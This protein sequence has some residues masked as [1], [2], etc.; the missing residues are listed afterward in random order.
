MTSP[1]FRAFSAHEAVW[2]LGA[3]TRGLALGKSVAITGVAT[4]TRALQP[5]DVFVAL[6]GKN[7]D[8]H[9]YL[10]QAAAAGASCAIVSN[11]NAPAM[12]EAPNLPLLLVNDTQVA[13]GEL[14]RW[15]RNR[16]D[17]LVIAITGTNGKTTVKEMLAHILAGAGPTLSTHKNENN[18]I[19][20]PKTLLRLRDDHAFA[21]IECGTSAPGEIARQAQ[22]AEPDFAILT[23]VGHGHLEGLGSFAGVVREKGA[24]L[25]GLGADAA[26][27]V[28]FDDFGA[29]Q[30]SRA[31]RAAVIPYGLDGRCAVRATDARIDE[32]G[33]SFL[34]NDA[35]AV[36]LRV[37]GFH[38]VRNA[39]AALTAA[40]WAGVP[41]EFAAMRLADFELPDLR[42]RRREIGQDSG[43]QPAILIDDCYNAN[44][45]S[46]AA[47]LQTLQ[48][49]PVP[50]VGEGAGRRIAVTGDMLELGD[51]A[52][53]HHDLLGEDIVRA[54][55]D[56]CL[57]VG[58]RADQVS[59]K[60]AQGGVDAY[61][62]D[63]AQTAAEVLA[64]EIAPGDVILIK[65]SRSVG[66]EIVAR[67]L[68]AHAD[69]IVARWQQQHPLARLSGGET[70]AA[71]C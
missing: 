2:V 41:L 35:H 25:A 24:L 49:Y 28:N 33:I 56:L 67:H 45:S 16:H 42:L 4:D 44:P 40:E 12:R 9:D 10:A 64:D 6:I 21:V 11:P 65:G 60:V 69:A 55:I 15:H 58:K 51:L 71:A 8:G 50:Q 57:A 47:A 14:A 27:A 59:E 39:L 37:M 32:D 22:I 3:K 19:G 68:Q 34:V 31:T 48:A 43:F 18:L 52:E 17:A 13:Y 20:V 63:D 61:A 29:I 1:D 38:N 30:A 62:I 36:N 53:H 46:M 26:C 54:D 70:A 5:G 7:H 23:N 66:L